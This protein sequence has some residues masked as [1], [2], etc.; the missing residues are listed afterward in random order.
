VFTGQSGSFARPEQCAVNLCD[1]L[2]CSS[3]LQW[4]INQKPT[5]ISEL[6]GNVFAGDSRNWVKNV[7]RESSFP[8][9]NVTVAT[10]YG[11]WAEYQPEFRCG[12]VSL[13]L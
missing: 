6:D 12:F 7:T 1:V 4:Q 2:I 10:F 8:P 9:K 13:R 3:W 5:V 11:L